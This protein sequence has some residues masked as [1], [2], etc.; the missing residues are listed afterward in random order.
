MGSHMP[1]ASPTQPQRPELSY[2]WTYCHPHQ[3]LKGKST[4]VLFPVQFPEPGTSL[5]Q[6][7]QCCEVDGM[8]LDGWIY[9]WMNKWMGKW[10]N[11]WVGGYMMGGW[12]DE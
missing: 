9:E 2:L 4:T 11:R 12:V 5:A 8:W 10:M 6:L 7:C 3:A 1:C